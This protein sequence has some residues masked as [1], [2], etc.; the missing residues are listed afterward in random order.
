MKMRKKFVFLM[1][2]ICVLAFAGS[3]LAAPPFPVKWVAT[4]DGYL[5]EDDQGAVLADTLIVV[6]NTPPAR[7]LI[8]MPVWIEVFDKY[9]T[10]IGEQTL[11]NGGD[12]LES[13]LIPINGY[14][15]ITLGMIV[16]RATHDP[17]GFAA[18][19]KFTLKISPGLLQT[20]PIVEIKQ[21]IYKSVQSSPGEA[22]W[23]AG[24][25]QTWAE[26]CLGGSK[27]P[28]ITQVPRKMK[29]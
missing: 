2:M 9:G 15:W 7:K 27:G 6:N 19:E 16:N 12:P 18:G 10:P 13:N 29:W 11:L 17:W 26:T 25:I 3:T 24:N 22:I 4:Y 21:V 14:G 28:D 23:Q 5:Q 8:S 1:A 20:P